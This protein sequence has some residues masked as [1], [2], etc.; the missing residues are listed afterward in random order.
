[1]FGIKRIIKEIDF[2]YED[3]FVVFSNKRYKVIENLGRNSF[4]LGSYFFVD[5]CFFMRFIGIKMKCIFIVVYN[6]KRF[7]R[8][9]N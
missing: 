9:I 2:D 3:V 1:M 7:V 6:L 5:V 4:V 8:G